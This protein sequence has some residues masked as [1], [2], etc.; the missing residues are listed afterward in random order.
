ME[1]PA[2]MN[3]PQ[4][5]GIEEQKLQ[6]L[7]SLVF[8]TQGKSQKELF[9]FLMTVAK[10]GKESNISFSDAEIHTIIDTLKKYSTPEELEK[11]NKVLALKKSR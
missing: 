6:F 8:E 5:A 10:M 4:V 9:S 1:K 7:Q 2:W 11:I 3:D